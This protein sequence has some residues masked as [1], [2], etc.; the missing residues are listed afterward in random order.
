MIVIAAILEKGDVFLRGNTKHRV[1]EVDDT[2]VYYSTDISRKNGIKHSMD[3]EYKIGIKSKEKMVLLDDCDVG[4][5]KNLGKTY[6]TSSIL[7]Q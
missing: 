5:P 6:M 1:T 3:R 4:D 7:N 2:H